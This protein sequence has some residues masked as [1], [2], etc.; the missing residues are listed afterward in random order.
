MV[1][2]VFLKRS[3][4]TDITN[5]QSDEKATGRTALGEGWPNKALFESRW[6]PA[7]V[8]VVMVNR[9]SSANFFTV[10]TVGG[11]YPRLWDVVKVIS[12]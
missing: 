8:G 10:D 1:R 9:F 4:K 12:I 6:E 7:Q 2:S 3:G 11:S 5:L